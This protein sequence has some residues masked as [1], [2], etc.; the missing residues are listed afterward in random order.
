MDDTMK[1]IIDNNNKDIDFYK[2]QIKWDNEMISLYKKQLKMD[3]FNDN[4]KYD[5]MRK[6]AG[7]YKVRKENK[8]RL[9]HYCNR[10]YENVCLL[11]KMKGG[12]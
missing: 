10:L 3:C 7:L 5:I 6:L 8:E 9:E 4:E 11:L 2:G 1:M 12:N